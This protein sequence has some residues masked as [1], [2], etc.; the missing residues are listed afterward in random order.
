MFFNEIYNRS[1]FLFR[2]FYRKDKPITQQQDT[3]L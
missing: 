2:V 3:S 1:F